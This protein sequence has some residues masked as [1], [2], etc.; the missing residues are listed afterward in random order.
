[1]YD[2]PPSGAV[3]VVY[4]HPT[5]LKAAAEAEAEALYPAFFGG[6]AL[7]LPLCGSPDDERDDECEDTAISDITGDSWEDNASM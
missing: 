6:W 1:M 4:S 7:S 2:E 5:K 3:N